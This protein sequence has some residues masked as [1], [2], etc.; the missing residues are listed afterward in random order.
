MHTAW[1][2][3]ACPIH[4]NE[5][6]HAAARTASSLAASSRCL[7]T[8]PP[9]HSPPTPPHHPAT[10]RRDFANGQFVK[11]CAPGTRCG[12]PKHPD[13]SPC[14]RG[15]YH[16]N[17]PFGNGG[18]I[19]STHYCENGVTCELFACFQLR[20]ACVARQPCTFG[21]P[22]TPVP[23]SP[24]CLLARP[25]RA[26]PSQH[27]TDK[28]GAPPALPSRRQVRIRPPLHRPR[29]GAP[30]RQ[31]PRRLS[32]LQEGLLKGQGLAAC[33]YGGS[34]APLRCGLGT[35]HSSPQEVVA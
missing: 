10:H 30:E 2:S 1:G 20:R 33:P 28:Q 19:D 32:L 23:N 5:Q 11:T 29:L 26:V 9:T 12:K 34:L 24:C 6:V 22:P 16:G 21:A 7:S 27:W 13:E 25:P 4:Q 8:P 18:C 3:T 14:L 17:C 35:R 31:G 15:S